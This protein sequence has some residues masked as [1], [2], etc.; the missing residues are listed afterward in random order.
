VRVCLCV[1][2]CVYVCVVITFRVSFG[3]VDP[4]CF[5]FFFSSDN[6]TPVTKASV[7]G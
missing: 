5:F 1:C 7:R 4:G 3:S 2:V 6:A